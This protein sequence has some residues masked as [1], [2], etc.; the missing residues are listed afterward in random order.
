LRFGVDWLDGSTPRS[1]LGCRRLLTWR[2]SRRAAWWGWLWWTPVFCEARVGGRISSGADAPSSGGEERAAAAAAE[3][4]GG[5][6]G[7]G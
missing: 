2:R 7:E 3:G 4:G 1:R 6:G 5:G